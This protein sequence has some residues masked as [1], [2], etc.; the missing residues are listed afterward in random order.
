MNHFKDSYEATKDAYIQKL[1]AASATIEEENLVSTKEL[2]LL[3]RRMELLK[4]VVVDTEEVPPWPYDLDQLL[5]LM[6]AGTLPF[7]LILLE[8]ILATLQI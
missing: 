8:R 7:I 6:A 3:I 4:I 1:A 5:R 2:D